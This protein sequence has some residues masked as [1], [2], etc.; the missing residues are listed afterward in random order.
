M[1]SQI[2]TFAAGCFWGVEASFLKLKGVIDTRVGYTGGHFPEPDYQLVCT[3][4]SGHAEAVRIV[5]D[6]D[7]IS[8]NE[9]LKEFWQM[10]DPTTPNRQGPDY[11]SQYRS[12]VFY[13]DVDQ[14]AA[15]EQTLSELQEMKKFD[16]MIVTEI[17]PAGEFYEAEEY[18]QRY[19]QKHNVNHCC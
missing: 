10:H 12:A 17:V 8:Y 18:H 15:A 19:Y 9:L 7:V 4:T 5:F 2:A 16:H 3:G 14:K 1:N 13:H 11:G 6:A